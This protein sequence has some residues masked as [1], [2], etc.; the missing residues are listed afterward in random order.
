MNVITSAY[1]FDPVSFVRKNDKFFF[2]QDT[3]G[4][5][6]WFNDSIIS[7]RQFSRKNTKFNLVRNGLDEIG[8]LPCVVSARKI[9]RSE[10]MILLSMNLCRNPSR[11]H[12]QAGQFRICEYN[13]KRFF[14]TE[15]M[16][17]PTYVWAKLTWVCGGSYSSYGRSHEHSRWIRNC[18]YNVKI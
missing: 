11:T 18:I 9:R 17:E 10:K 2:E 6:P 4:S 7:H 1:L 8:S 12:N 15:E 14:S 3:T 5:D 16:H 13:A